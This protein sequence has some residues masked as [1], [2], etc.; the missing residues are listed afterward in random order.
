MN[1]HLEPCSFLTIPATLTIYYFLKPIDMTTRNIS[2]AEAKQIDMVDF[3][4][5]LG[6][7]PK[8]I[9]NNDHWYLSPLR[10]ENRLLLK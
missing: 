4:K 5:S 3:L 10:E 7:T 1:T 2:I 6:Y 8:K 9:R